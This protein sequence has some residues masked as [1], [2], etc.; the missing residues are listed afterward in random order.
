MFSTKNHILIVS[1]GL[2]FLFCFNIILPLNIDNPMNTSSLETES[3]GLDSLSTP[4]YS[5]GVLPLDNYTMDDTASY[6]WIEISSSGTPLV[7]GDDDSTSIALPFAFP[8]YDGLFSTIFS[9]I[10]N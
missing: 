2:L 8:F 7:L 10:T 9:G 3:H 1:L 5:Y 6:N 4:S